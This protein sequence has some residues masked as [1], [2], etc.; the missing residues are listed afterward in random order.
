MRGVA[1]IRYLDSTGNTRL[2]AELRVLRV[3]LASAALHL[4][5]CIGH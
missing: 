5:D 2:L 1:W 4:C 3:D